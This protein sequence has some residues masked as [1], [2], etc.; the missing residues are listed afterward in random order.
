MNNR[1]FLFLFLTIVVWCACSNT[2]SWVI[3]EKEM[4]NV[5]F[6]IHLAEA[7]IDRDYNTY[8]DTLKKKRLFDAVF[9]KYGVSREAFDTSLVWYASNLKT[10]MGM[11]ER[12]TTRFNVLNDT[13]NGRLT[14]LNELEAKAKR[15]WEKDSLFILWPANGE[16]IYHFR[17]DT[18][19]YFS[20]GDLY[21]LNCVVY[22]VSESFQP[23][24][25]FSWEGGDTCVI[26]R[27]RIL[28]N[29]VY[30][31]YLETLPGIQ[32]KAISGSIRVP[33]KASGNKLIVDDLYLYKYKEGHHPKIEIPE[34]LKPDSL[35]ADT[36]LLVLPDKGKK[37]LPK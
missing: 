20:S 25:T 12:I 32:T 34:P 19:S 10:Y 16:H 1:Q 26:K 11:Y 22:G 29:G 35:A 36:S 37:L 28:R 31:L 6:D 8:N 9:Q 15:L 33:V 17:L 2:P 30:K 24:V 13:L 18:S 14:K 7:E 21:E 5:L 23:K 3:P 27:E 4:E